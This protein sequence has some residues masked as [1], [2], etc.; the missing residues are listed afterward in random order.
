MSMQLI[1]V[2]YQNCSEKQILM[3]VAFFLNA[4]LIFLND[5]C[6]TVCAIRTGVLMRIMELHSLIAMAAR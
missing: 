2:N 5:V 6:A 4:N 1:T 3:V